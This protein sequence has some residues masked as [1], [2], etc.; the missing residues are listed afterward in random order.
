MR[1]AENIIRHEIIGLAA[2]VVKANN[3]NNLKISGEIID[4]TKKTLTIEQKGTLKR[5]FKDQ[6]T[7]Q[8]TLPKQ[9]VDVNGK[10]LLGRPWE[11]LNKKVD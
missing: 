11:R 1:T 7:L 6:V 8:L 2:K 4:E 10:L 3:S 9:T 5:I